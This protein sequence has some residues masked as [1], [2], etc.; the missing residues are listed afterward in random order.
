[1][2]SRSSILFVM[3]PVILLSAGIGGTLLFRWMV[4]APH[5]V[6]MPSLPGM[7]G[8][9]TPAERAVTASPDIDLSG[10]LQTYDGVASELPGRWPRFRGASFDNM[11]E[12][13]TAL[14]DQ[15]PESGPRILWSVALGEGHAAPAVFDGCV[16]L[17]DYDEE[18]RADALRCFSLEDGKEIWRRSYPLPAKRNHGLSRTIPAV[19]EQWTVTMGPRCHVSC[20][21]TG[22][23][24]FL[25]GIDLQ[26]EYGTTEPLWFTGQCPLI[27]G[28]RAIIAPGGP[29]VLMMAVDCADGSVKWTVPNP[30]GWSM[31]HSSIMPMTIHGEEMYVYVAVGGITGVSKEGRRLWEI[32]WNASVVA[33]SPVLLDDNRIFITAGYGAGSLMFRIDRKDDEFTAT[34]LSRNG[35]KEWLASEQQT[36][37]YRD[38]LL[39]GIM[40]KD[41]GALKQQFVCY[42]PDSGELVWSSGKETRF[43]LGPYILANDRF[44]ILDD[45]GT[46]SMLAYSRGGYEP[47]ARFRVL[48]GHDAWGP[49]AVVGNRMLLRDSTRMVCIDIGASQ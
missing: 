45:D 17:L 19:T 22:T 13:D 27:D 28:G 14:A 38:G 49:I 24:R 46:L 36:P 16:Y 37:I 1:M 8:G 41:A 6:V 33:P 40:P 39:F 42:D 4:P 29:D 48:D 12:S 15:W 20:V 31:S 44:Y 30:N 11:V 32:P 5:L 35:P 21:D 9:P 3:L 25:W 10:S 7:D 18:N 26:K 47:L 34:E 2:K 23:G 43:G